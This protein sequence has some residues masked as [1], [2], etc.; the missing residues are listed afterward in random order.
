MLSGRKVEPGR[1][2]GFGATLC[3]VVSGLAGCSTSAS[4]V[5]RTFE[6]AVAPWVSRIKAAPAEASGAPTTPAAPGFDYLRVSVNGKPVWLARGY[7]DPAE[8]GAVSVWYSAQAEVL[9]LQR[10]RLAG[11]VGTPLSWVRVEGIGTAPP[12][13]DLPDSGAT[14]QRRV[15]QMPGHQWALQDTLQVRRIGPPADT[16]LA[17][18][19]PNDLVWVEEVD[20]RRRLPPSRY[21]WKPGQA[22][23]VYGEQCLKSDFCLAWQRWP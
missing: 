3:L 12:G 19:S 21:A 15:D 1:F 10:G 5:Q 22:D 23:P 8:G 14:W 13:P 18:L 2:F 11:L 7:T 4:P 17:G 6:A 20:T 9:R 16:Q